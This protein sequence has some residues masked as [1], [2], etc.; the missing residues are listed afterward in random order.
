[1]DAAYHFTLFQV[2]TFRTGSE[3]L[4]IRTFPYAT[5]KAV[6]KFHSLFTATSTVDGFKG[7]ERGIEL[8]LPLFGGGFS[9]FVIIF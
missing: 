3:S 7:N 6:R 9:Q 8:F 1:M 2:R 4:A 5:F